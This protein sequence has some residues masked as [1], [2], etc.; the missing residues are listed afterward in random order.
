MG[1]VFHMHMDEG[2]E[3]CT[4]SRTLKLAHINTDLASCLITHSVIP[5]LT[6]CVNLCYSEY[7]QHQRFSCS[8]RLRSWIKDTNQI[9]QHIYYSLITGTVMIGVEKEI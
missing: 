4:N 6:S 8:E 3:R 9:N 5:T 7:I 2:I 1:L